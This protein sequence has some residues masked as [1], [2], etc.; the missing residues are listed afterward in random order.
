MPK[1]YEKPPIIEA[2]C[3]FRFSGKSKWD[4]TIPGLI[5]DSVKDEYPQK[6]IGIRG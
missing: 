3:E 5:Y 1:K 6:L 4:L 2:V